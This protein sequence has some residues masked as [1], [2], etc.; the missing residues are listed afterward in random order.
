MK[1]CTL[2]F[3]LSI[4]FYLQAQPAIK[5]FTLINVADDRQLSLYSLTGDAGL[6]IIF[7][8]NVCPFD[9]Y[10]HDRIRQLVNNYQGKIQFV[11]INACQEPEESIEKMKSA[12]TRWNLPIP[13]LADKEQSAMNEL[14]AKKSPEVFLLSGAP[15]KYKILYSGAIDDNPQS[16]AAVTTTYL[17]SAIDKLLAGHHTEV[18]VTRTVGCTI[19][20]K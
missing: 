20:R 13:Y 11:L 15:G 4:G 14:G 6:A 2:V 10:Y 8:S 12:Y 18:N 3:L 16:P 5:D 9:S 1:Y 17:K 19:R 7:T